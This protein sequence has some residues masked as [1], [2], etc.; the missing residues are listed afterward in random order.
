MAAV[1]I[2]PAAALNLKADCGSLAEIPYWL[3]ENPVLEVIGGGAVQPRP[4][5]AA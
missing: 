4:T 1:T 2:N 3:G 5:F